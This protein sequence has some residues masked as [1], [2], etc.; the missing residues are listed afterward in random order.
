MVVQTE[1]SE[2]MDELQKGLNLKQYMIIDPSNAL[3]VNS[4]A[5]FL[6]DA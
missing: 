3:E 2:L 5:Y 4:G 1:N 6:Y